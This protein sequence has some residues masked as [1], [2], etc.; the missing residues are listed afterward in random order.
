MNLGEKVI[1]KLD[2]NSKKEQLYLYFT[3]ENYL[4]DTSVQTA[5]LM[6]LIFYYYFIDARRLGKCLIG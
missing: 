3:F 2:N 6:L 4:Y 5:S 1:W